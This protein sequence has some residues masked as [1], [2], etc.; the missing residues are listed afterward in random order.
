MSELF[1]WRPDPL[2]MKE[3]IPVTPMSYLYAVRFKGPIDPLVLQLR[4]EVYVEP[5]ESINWTRQRNNVNP[6]DIYSPHHPVLDIAHQILGLY[7]TLPSLSAFGCLPIRKMAIKE[8]F[9]RVKMEDENTTYQTLGPVSKSFNLL[10]R[11]HH[12]GPESEAFKMHLTRV[13]DFLWLSKEGLFMTG[14][15]GSQLWDLAF[16]A[17]A[18]VE[19]GLAELD[20]NK[21]MCK[22]M[23]DWLDKAQMRENP[24]HYEAAYRHRTKGA[25]GFSTKEQGY[26][27]SRHRHPGFS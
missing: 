11:Y 3:L 2:T 16:M 10:V 21:E 8:A 17:Q 1:V 9:R 25:W 5:Y 13:E 15:N 6:V 22:G 27:V 20:E 4:Q 26:T 12:D 18:A 7:E 14:T 23:L 24:K 19:T